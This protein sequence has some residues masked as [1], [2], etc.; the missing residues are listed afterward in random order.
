MRFCLSKWTRIDSTRNNIGVGGRAGSGCRGATFTML[1]GNGQRAAGRRYPKKSGRR[2][3]VVETQTGFA[4]SPQGYER[5][6]WFRT[7]DSPA[8]HYLRRY[9]G[10]KRSDQ[11]STIGIVAASYG[12]RLAWLKTRPRHEPTC[13]VSPA[14]LDVDGRNLLHLPN[15]RARYLDTRSYSN[16]YSPNEHSVNG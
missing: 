14:D 4:V 16:V 9:W 2:A 7:P 15:S 3:G 10:P 5:L 1:L 6:E 8:P 11:T 13:A 12:C